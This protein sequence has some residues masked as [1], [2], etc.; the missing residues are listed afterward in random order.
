MMNGLK[1]LALCASLLVA[2]CSGGTDEQNTQA[3]QFRSV[4]DAYRAGRQ[5]VAPP[6]QLTPAL[7]ASLTVPALEVTIENRNATAFLVPF[8]ERRDA[9]PGLVRTW[10][11]ADDVQIIVRDGVIAA[12]RGVSNDIGSVDADAAVKAIQQRSPISGRHTLYIKNGNNGIDEIPLDCEMRTVG[13]E[14]LVI[15]GRSFP[16]V[17]LQE[18]CTGWKGVVAFDYWVDRRDATVWQTRQWSG[19]GL[20]YIRTRLLKK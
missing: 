10:R 4:L 1:S 2:G 7:I 8:S 5:D 12:T 20:G 18:N 19:P 17:H 6:P 3:S 13:N 11:S 14:D 15:V 9:G 16:V